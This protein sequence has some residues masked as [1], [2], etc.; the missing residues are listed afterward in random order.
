MNKRIQ[1]LIQLLILLSIL[2][3][4]GCKSIDTGF[5]KLGYQK[6]DEAN[7]K[8]SSIQYESNNKLLEIQRQ[9]DIETKKFIEALN[10]QMQG[11]ADE[12]FAANYAFSLN[13]KPDRNSI[14]VNYHV[15]S[16]T[17][18]LKMPPSVEA[19]NKHLSEVS[20]ELDE[21]KTTLNELNSK[22]LE[23]V[24]KA[25]QIIKDKN[26]IVNR[27]IKLEQDKILAEKE[28]DEKIKII[29][30]QKDADAQKILD[31]QQQALNE[32]KDREKLIRKLTIGAGII[33]VIFLIIAVYLPAFRKESA[34]ISGIMGGVAISLPFIE[35]WMVITAL[36]IIF[37]GLLIWVGI[38]HVLSSKNTQ[39]I[40]D[41]E[42]RVSKNLVNVIQDIKDKN[43]DVFD[44]H[45]KPVLEDWNT[46]VTKNKDGSITK[47][48]DTEVEH[49]IDEKLISSDRK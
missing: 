41:I 3:I 35:P 46:I 49:V 19:V 13:L 28:R 34:I 14:V 32:S 25:D 26:E 9:K 21:T 7:K 4:T 20:R 23:Q 29:Q 44:N 39:K 37:F 42:S 38:K 43:R 24:S 36:S 30:D 8:I 22:Y 33:S 47:I 5:N 15:R 17:E 2:L 27:N 45:I 11:A 18:Y 10:N 6:I 16:A 40:V 12:L 48:K 1:L 31:A